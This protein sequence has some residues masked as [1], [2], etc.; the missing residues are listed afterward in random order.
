MTDMRGKVF[1]PTFSKPLPADAAIVTKGGERFAR[2]TD[3]KNRKR[4][5][6]LTADG[7][8]V[9]IDAECYWIRYRDAE[10]RVKREPTNCRTLDGA[11]IVLAERLRHVERVASGA[12]SA[13]EAA[14]ADHR[15]SAIDVH[16]DEY[17]D[18]LRNK[19]GRGGKARVSPAHVRNVEA[20]LRRILADCGFAKLRDFSRRAVEKWAEAREAEATSTADGNP[21]G[22][23]GRRI[24]AHVEALGAFAGWLVAENRLLA[25]PFTRMKREAE[26]RRPRRAFTAD[27]LARLI[28]AA[29]R[30]PVAEHGRDGRKPLTPANL[31]ECERRG[32]ERLS[33]KRRAEAEHRGQGRAVLYKAAALTGLRWN[34]LRS[35]RIRSLVLDE[36]PAYVVVDANAA[37]NGERAELVL[38]P[39]LAADVRAMLAE[40]LDTLRETARAAGEPI[41]AKLSGESPLFDM[42]KQGIRIFDL[43]LDAAGI[44]K[45]DDRGRSADFHCLRHSFASHL[46]AAG[47]EARAVQFAMRHSTLNLTARYTDKRLV[48]VAAA[49]DRLPALPLDSTPNAGRARATGTDGQACL[50]IACPESGENGRELGFS[51]VDGNSAQSVTRDSDDTWRVGAGSD[52][53]GENRTRQESNL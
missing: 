3:R 4:E 38:R 16:V 15:K 29:A 32:R 5:A 17:L 22:M 48:N 2:W 6:R 21:S 11:G 7:A 35:L 52:G 45:I 31:A 36:S 1:K 25:N 49:L 46:A 34:E 51:V 26:S 18:A 50:S 40:R 42:P 19:R 8:G 37:K 12:I 33:A 14:A 47:V 13:T 20:A 44:P 41:P 23:S 24:N 30:R 27:E 53:V 28:D 43:D 9:L 39:D 10:G